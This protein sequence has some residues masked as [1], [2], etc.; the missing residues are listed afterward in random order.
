MPSP[1]SC[2][3]RSSGRSLCLGTLIETVLFL[4]EG[5][6]MSTLYFLFSEVEIINTPLWYWYYFFV[7]FV[8]IARLR[9]PLWT[10]TIWLANGEQVTK[11]PLCLPKHKGYFRFKNGWGGLIWTGDPPE[12]H[13]ARKK[14][15]C[16]LPPFWVLLYA[17]SVT[18]SR[19]SAR[20]F[21]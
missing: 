13:V 21:E 14:G 15:G 4:T 9:N 1:S 2:L 5:G 3:I 6:I 11:Y 20:A 19:L 10:L 16:R 18:V 7:P 12:P 17:I 8:T